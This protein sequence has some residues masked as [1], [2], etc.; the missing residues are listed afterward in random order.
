MMLGSTDKEIA[1]QQPIVPGY[2]SSEWAH[3]AR[4]L[5]TRQC[6]NWAED[7]KKDKIPEQKAFLWSDFTNH[8]CFW[9][10]T[11]PPHYQGAV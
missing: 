5:K 2:Y 3:N 7:T 8:Y 4:K 9:I 1:S 6:L 10:P 11:K